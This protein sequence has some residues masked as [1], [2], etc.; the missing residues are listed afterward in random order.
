MQDLVFLYCSI[1][2]FT[3]V[4]DLNTSSTTAVSQPA[5]YRDPK[6][7]TIYSVTNT[8]AEHKAQNRQTQHLSFPSRLIPLIT[9]GLWSLFGLKYSSQVN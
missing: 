7:C 9:L 8:I 1:V 3:Q 6:P 5:Q 2:T 4:K